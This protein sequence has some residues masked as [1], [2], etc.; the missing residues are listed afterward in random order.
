MN[1]CNNF[2]L[3][4]C[5]NIVG[6]I[7]FICHIV[8]LPSI[9][10]ILSI[11]LGVYRQPK[12]FRKPGS[13]APSILFFV[14]NAHLLLPSV[15]FLLLLAY[16]FCLCLSF[17]TSW[18]LNNRNANAVDMGLI[19]PDSFDEIFPFQNV[20]QTGYTICTISWIRFKLSIGFFNSLICHF[21]ILSVLFNDLLHLHWNINIFHNCNRLIF[22]HCSL[23][24]IVRSKYNE[25]CKLYMFVYLVIEAL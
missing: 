16:F 6:Q 9:W 5:F 21:A 11:L 19:I 4:L 3:V 14:G 23:F 18:L 8:H 13:P 17:S 1:H 7:V 20:H 12:T 22:Q 15:Y 10:H 24:Y 2:P 25:Q